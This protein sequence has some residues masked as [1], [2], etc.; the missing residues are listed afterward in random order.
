MGQVRVQWFSQATRSQEQT[1]HRKEE[2]VFFP[3]FT[4]GL[5][6]RAVLLGAAQSQ[7]FHALGT[8]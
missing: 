6:P 1:V 7:G 5:M 3:C 2:N 8:Q 4:L